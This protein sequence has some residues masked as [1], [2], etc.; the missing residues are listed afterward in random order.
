MRY[1][2]SILLC[3]ILQ[4]GFS[5]IY[6]TVGI[7]YTNGTP[8]YTPAK[9]GSALALDT[10]TWRYYT[11]NGTTW[12]SD[13]FRVQTI[14]GCSAPAYTPT[15]FQSL[16]VINACNDAQGGP[17][18][19]KWS[20]S[21]WEKSGGTAYTAGTGIAI[22]GGN[23]I[24]S[25]I[26]Q[27]DGSETKINVGA[28]LSK[29]GS[30]TTGSPYVLT[31][32][33]P[34]TPDSTFA[35]ING[36]YPGKTPNSNVYRSGKS[37]FGTTD[38]TAQVNVR[39]KNPN[40]SVLTYSHNYTTPPRSAFL[41]PTWVN[42]SVYKHSRI[43][44]NNMKFNHFP[45]FK[46]G[47]WTEDYS[48]DSTT[49]LPLGP[50]NSIRNWGFNQDGAEP[51]L[52][53]WY[54]STEQNYYL[55]GHVPSWEYHLE[56][57]DTLT[58]QIRPF[59]LNGFH[60]GTFYGAGFY[61]NNFYVKKARDGREAL[62]IDIDAGLWRTQ[63]PYSFRI[64][65][66]TT[67]GPI[68]ER[69]SIGRF[70]NILNF[71]TNRSVEV[72]DSNGIVL[73]N[74]IRFRA[75]SS[76]PTF[77]AQTGNIYFDS[78]K[79]T[80]ITNDVNSRYEVV[81]NVG[82]ANTMEHCFDGNSYYMERNSGALRPVSYDL[83][84]P[85]YSLSLAQNGDFAVG[86][87]FNA[88][89]W[90]AKFRV[91]DNASP[92]RVLVR[93]DNSEGSKS[94]YAHNTPSSLG[95]IDGSICITN[96]VLYGKYLA[97]WNKYLLLNDASGAIGGQV[98]TWDAGTGR[99]APATPAASVVIADFYTDVSNTGTS[100]TDLY[101]HTVAANSITA[102]GMKIIASFAFTLNDLTATNQIRVSFAGTNIANTGALTVSAT[103]GGK[104][105]VLII[106]SGT[107]TARAVVNISTPGASTAIYTSQTDLTGLDFT[108][109]NILKITGQAAGATGG[110]GDITAKLGTIERKLQQ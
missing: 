92:T 75:L 29:S 34:N 79:L 51:T 50:G 11:W 73:T 69:L 21:V 58:R 95:G 30:G 52:S 53:R 27:A 97:A 64:A 107:T 3:V 77:Y 26:T 96:G 47:T 102:N 49:N 105:D 72:G 110:T 54:W 68:I 12:I 20:G 84:S 89:N 62:N 28:G 108:A 38:T 42:G 9:A 5:Q 74:K 2:F 13:G 90:S 23:V 103:G 60:N 109:T 81:K 98:L 43:D 101:S 35:L 59:L 86:P 46:Y 83:R 57:F 65:N 10:V 78:L 15:K 4:T 85:T 32:T 36:Q 45:A 39:P 55:G 14:S 48:I 17:E 82:N 56:V 8:T 76:T 106:R 61:V 40:G 94:I 104:A 19:Y 100:E 37:G 18:I 22:S 41:G 71:N 44:L 6:K 24:S 66:D 88:T 16:V 91:F 67:V 7:S 70:H 25:T 63:L 31:N 93:L 99:W 33:A 87:E 80:I 1:I